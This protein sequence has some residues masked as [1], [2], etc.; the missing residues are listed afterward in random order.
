MRPTRPVVTGARKAACVIS[1]SIS[2]MLATAS[3]PACADAPKETVS[4][5]MLT[6][7]QPVPEL[8]KARKFDEALIKLR[9]ADAVANKSA[10]ESYLIN[11]MRASAAAGAGDNLLAAKSYEAMIA[12]NRLPASEVLPI[13][14]VIARMYYNVKEYKQAA[15]WAARYLKEGGAGVQNSPAR[16]LMVNAMYFAGDYEGA[17]PELQ[18][19]VQR[20]ERVGQK[21]TL[22]Q[23]QM[24][25]S[26]EQK[27][28]DQAAYVVTLE[29]LV[30]YYPKDEFWKD[31]IFRVA[32]KPT[33]SSSLNLNMSRLRYALGQ[34]SKPAD[35]LDLAERANRSGFPI[36]AKQI[37]D[38]GFEK[39]VLGTGVDAANHKKLREQL[40][41]EAAD[42]QK[43]IKRAEAVAT[44]AS[45]GTGLIGVGFNYVII[46]DTDKGVALMEQGLKKGGLKRPDEA[47][48]RL[49]MAYAM[50]GQKQK[51]IETLKSVHGADGIEDL[52]RLWSLFANQ[53]GQTGQ[54]EVTRAASLAS[55]NTGLP[56]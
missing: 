42:D 55:A 56:K 21:P 6:P 27:L 29:K 44:K 23:L 37:L 28:N 19:D 33:F 45:D 31:L 11:Q 4:A 47:T 53:S 30:A 13:M 5:A 34:L 2:A 8:I 54:A 49:G 35:Y 43:D 26:A 20:I 52:A 51:A 16:E 12:A 18:A 1:I 40:G 9:E 36:E 17:R 25:A 50:A 3:M 14:D 7:L 46:G 41:K 24:L 48:L 32:S 39:G 10:Y 22:Q 38:Q 15:T